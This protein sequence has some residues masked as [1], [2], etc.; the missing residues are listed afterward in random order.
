MQVTRVTNAVAARA[1]VR[2]AQ[3]RVVDGPDRGL[4]VDLPPVGVV[5]G[6]ERTCDVVLADTFVSRRHCSVTPHAQGFAIT[7]LGSRNGTIIDGV[8]IHKVVAPPG[9]AIRIGK[10][11][12]Q[13]MPADEAVDIPPSAADRFGALYGASHV[14]RQVFGLLERAARSTAPIL[15]L[16][17]SGTGKEL[18]ARGIHDA[19]PRKDGPFV[20]FDCGASTETLIESDLFGHTKGAFTGAAGDR[21]GAF[22]AAHGGTL[23]LDEIGDL[24]VALQP[25]LLRMLEAGEVVP[26]GGR[27]SERYDVRIVA[28]THRDVFG[29]VAR[30]G[31]RGD[32]YYRLA[33]VE[34]HVPPLRQR[35]GDLPQLIRMFLERAG[36]PQLASGVGGP[37]LEKLQRYHWPGNVRELRNVITRAVALAG[38][39]DDF[40]SIPFVLRPTVAAPDDLGPIKADRPF[41]EAKD[42]LVARFEREYLTDLVQR[43]GGNLSQAARDAGLERKFLYKV[44]E[45]AGLRQPAPSQDKADDDGTE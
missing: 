27:K 15:F 19:S 22:A 35:T 29:E 21:Q 7:D 17:E 25:K 38:P 14:M 1:P 23:F 41:H 37:A 30:G 33:V 24:P 16:G 12:V 8:A 5:I 13:L 10:T 9:V 34:V 6:T 44:L 45:R 28:A 3:L 18:M 32:L 11:L 31:F 36:A 43:A 42:A 26:L 20:V 4:A 40:Q 39:D 2:A